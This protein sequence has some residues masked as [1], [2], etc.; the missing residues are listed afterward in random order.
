MEYSKESQTHTDMEQFEQTMDINFNS[1]V[2]VIKAFLPLLTTSKGRVITVASGAGQR[3][4]D[5][6]DIEHKVNLFDPQIKNDLFS[7]IIRMQFG[8]PINLVRKD[9]KINTEENSWHI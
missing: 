9:F 5:I 6:L 4:L 7:H 1:T 2:R 8:F 3:T